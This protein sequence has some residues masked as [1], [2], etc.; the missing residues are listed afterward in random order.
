MKT[1]EII[2]RL[3]NPQKYNQKVV[4]AEKKAQEEQ[5]VRT[6]NHTFLNM[7]AW[8]MVI[9]A[10]GAAAIVM[11]S[12]LNAKNRAEDITAALDPKNIQGLASNTDFNPSKDVTYVQIYEGQ[13]RNVA[14]DELGTTLPIINR[15]NYQSITPKNYGI[16]GMAPW[17]L[18]ENFASNI[19]DPEIIRY[20][21]NREEVA[22]AFISRNDVAPLLEDPQLLAAF[23]Q[24]TVKLNEFFES[25]TVKQVLTNPD[26]VRKIGGSRFMSYLLTSKSIKYYRDHPAE[27][28]KVINASPALSALRQ[29]AGIRQA[30][31]ENYYLKSIASQLLGPARTAY[32]P[33]ANPTQKQASRKTSKK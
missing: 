2:D 13:D 9:C 5:E 29:N 3:R 11:L 10:L 25:N 17:A 19:K 21:L 6:Q 23:T 14:V 28:I 31:T 22:K 12:V 1:E 20:L 16:I 33:A 30:V 27:A 32:A 4:A 7:L 8:G 18:T 26:I 15:F 24:D